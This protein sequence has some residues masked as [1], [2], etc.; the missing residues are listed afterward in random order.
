MAEWYTE[1]VTVLEARVRSL[2]ETGGL[3][4][5]SAAGAE[6]VSKLHLEAVQLTE[7]VLL[8]VEALRK[9]VKKMERAAEVLGML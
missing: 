6:E 2:E 8:N 9:I 1:K 3:S 4:D 5:I 7:F